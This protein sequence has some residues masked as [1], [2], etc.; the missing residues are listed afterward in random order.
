[1]T[2]ITFLATF[3][4]ALMVSVIFADEPGWTDEERAARSTA[5]FDGRVVMVKRVDAINDH[6]DLYSSVISVETAF[7]GN[8]LVDKDKITVYFERPVYGD[9]GKRCPAYVELKQARRAS[10]S[11]F[12]H[13][14]G[15]EG[16]DAR[17]L[18]N[19]QLRIF[20]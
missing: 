13:G 8:E 12:G 15:R 9:T 20:S 17:S 6:V 4:A 7:K 16:S 18:S 10:A 1:M 5:V 2:R 19:S 11:V 3:V 14:I